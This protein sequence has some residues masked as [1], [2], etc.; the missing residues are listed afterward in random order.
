MDGRVT[1]PATPLQTAHLTLLGAAE[2][3]GRLDERG[4]RS[5][6]DVAAVL[7]ARN[8]ARL[9]DVDGWRAA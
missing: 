6:W 2:I 8:L 4:Q 7:V 9:G 5:F 3:A 1:E